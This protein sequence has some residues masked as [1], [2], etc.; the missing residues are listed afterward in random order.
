[1]HLPVYTSELAENAVG[2]SAKKIDQLTKANCCEL[3]FDAEKQVY[4][5]GCSDF[6]ENISQAAG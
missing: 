2:H 6:T 5:P 1:M 4:Q 3:L